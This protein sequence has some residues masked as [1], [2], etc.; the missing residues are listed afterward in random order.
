MNPSTL[1]TSCLCCGCCCLNAFPNAS[2]P[3]GIYPV[4]KSFPSYKP[5]WSSWSIGTSLYSTEVPELLAHL[6]LIVLYD[7]LSL[8]CM[9]LITSSSLA[10]SHFQLRF[11]SSNHGPCMG[12]ISNPSPIRTPAFWLAALRLALPNSVPL[13]SRSLSPNP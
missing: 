5:L 12:F 7:K 9:F 10:H 3:I 13:T 2:L 11:S 1:T 6:S 8:S 4:L